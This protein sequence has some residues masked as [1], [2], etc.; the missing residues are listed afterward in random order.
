M[1]APSRSPGLNPRSTRTSQSTFANQRFADRGR[2][3]V[4]EGSLHAVEPQFAHEVED[5]GAFHQLILTI[6]SVGSP[7]LISRSGAGA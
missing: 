6:A 4:I 2:H 1:N 5:L 3:D 7:P